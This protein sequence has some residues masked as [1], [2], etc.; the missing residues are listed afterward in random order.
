MKRAT[1]TYDK[2]GDGDAAKTA[3]YS[4]KKLWSYTS[5]ISSLQVKRVYIVC[6]DASGGFT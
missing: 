6:D 2:Q 4:P 5:K 3:D 1:D